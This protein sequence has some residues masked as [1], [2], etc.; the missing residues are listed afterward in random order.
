MELIMDRFG[1][2]LMIILS[3]FLI[4]TTVGW[5]TCSVDLNKR[6]KTLE[7]CCDEVQ[8]RLDT[9]GSTDVE[10][11]QGYID[12]KL[13]EAEDRQTQN[14]AQLISERSDAIKA[15]LTESFKEDIQSAVKE[16]SQSKKTTSKKK[17]TKTQSTSTEVQTATAQTSTNTQITVEP[18]KESNMSDPDDKHF[19]VGSAEEEDE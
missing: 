10:Q 4:G 15:E 7:G 8:S 16:S 14:A 11:I 18:Q 5:I 12:Q 9:V 2:L 17:S 6:V 3:V 1:G 19:K 13:Q